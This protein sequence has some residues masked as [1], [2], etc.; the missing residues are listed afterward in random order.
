MFGICKPYFSQEKPS[1]FAGVFC[2]MHIGVTK[3][4]DAHYELKKEGK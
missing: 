3:L 4:F 1:H 2:F